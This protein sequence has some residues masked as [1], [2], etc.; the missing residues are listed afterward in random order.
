MKRTMAMTVLA[1]PMLLGLRATSADA[2]TI[3]GAGYQATDTDVACW[4]NA[5]HSRCAGA[6]SQAQCASFQ[7]DAWNEGLLTFNAL[8]WLENNNYCPI[9]AADEIFA[10]CAQGCFAGETELLTDVAGNGK[11]G[12]ASASKMASTMTASLASGVAS[13]SKLMSMAD[14]A[15]LRSVSLTSRSVER[16]VNGP[17]VPPLFVF[18]LSNGSTLR[19]TQHHPMVLHSGKIIEASQVERHNAFMGTD[20]RRVEILSITREK[21]DSDVFNFQTA[22]ETQLSHVIVAEGVLVGDL[23]LQNELQD[24][25]NSISLRK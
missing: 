10:V 17:E 20:G 16:F 4:A 3:P 2:C 15:G 14:D 23:K 8:V 25:E 11:L 5:D 9:V 18:T 12:W 24:E 13:G 7:S 19:V 6:I 22:G 21:T 1:V